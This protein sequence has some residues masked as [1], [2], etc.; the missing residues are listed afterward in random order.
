MLI[1]TRGI[2]LKAI[3]YGETS[4][5][6]DVYTEQRGLRKYIINGVRS[7][8]ARIPA[9]LLQVISLIEMV[10]YNRDDRQLN[11]VKEMRAAYVYQSLPFDVRKGA[12][13]LFMAEVLRKTIRESE[14]N[15]ALFAFLADTFQYLDTTT[16]AVG[17]LHLHFLLELSA[18]LGFV[19]D[20]AFGADTP[21]FDLQEGVFVADTPGH[22]H[23]LNP[24]L[25]ERLSDLLHCSLAH[26]HEVALGAA[27]RRQLLQILLDFYRLHLDYMPEIHAHEVL[28]EVLSG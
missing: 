24:E 19:P 2:V 15:T 10:A 25:S 6:A 3:R 21:C 22:R 11:H 5:I 17:N 20:G 13:A 26:C 1:K 4:V 16:H 12:I 8:K 14:E 27:Q 9:S 7:R 18:F 28:H 23:F